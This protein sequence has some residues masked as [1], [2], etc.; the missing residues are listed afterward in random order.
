MVF[1]NSQQI[2]LTV[3]RSGSFRTLLGYYILL[4]R[5]TR[6]RNLKLGQALIQTAQ[7]LIGISKIV[8]DTSCTND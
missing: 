8:K 4:L 5:F 7:S 1:Y 3:H 2:T 6:V